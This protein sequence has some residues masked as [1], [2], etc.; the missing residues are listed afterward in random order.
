[1]ADWKE[2]SPSPSMHPVGFIERESIPCYN[3]AMATLQEILESFEGLPLD[4]G[5]S[6]ESVRKCR[7]L[8][9]RFPPFLSLLT[10]RI[11]QDRCLIGVFGKSLRQTPETAEALGALLQELKRLGA[12]ITYLN[13]SPGA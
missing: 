6:M 4:D 7:H 1:M 10:I 8:L 5:E 11:S 12:R 9:Y 2:S 13:P 3:A